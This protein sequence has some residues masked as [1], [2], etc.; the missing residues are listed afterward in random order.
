MMTRSIR[1]PTLTEWFACEICTFYTVVKYTSRGW[2]RLIPRLFLND[3]RVLKSIHSSICAKWT[4]EVKFCVCFRPIEVQ[5]INTKCGT[6]FHMMIR[7]GIFMYTSKY[8]GQ[9]MDCFLQVV[10]FIG[11][12]HTTNRKI[13]LIQHTAAGSKMSYLLRT[14]NAKSRDVQVLY[15]SKGL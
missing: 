5:A 14:T 13:K 12:T 3:V 15:C 1:E 11:A 2:L 10:H 4:N 7:Y 9:Y 6:E 8:I